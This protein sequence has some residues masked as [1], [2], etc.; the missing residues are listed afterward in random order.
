MLPLILSN[1]YD[2]YYKYK[3][4]HMDG[5]FYNSTTPMELITMKGMSTP[6]SFW[7]YSSGVSSAATSPYA[8]YGSSVNMGGASTQNLGTNNATV[9]SN[10][11][12][13]S[14]NFLIRIWFK[15]TASKY[16]RILEFGGGDSIALS[17]W[18]FWTN[19][20]GTQWAFQAGTGGSSIFTVN[21]TSG[22]S[23]TPTYVGS[24]T[25]N[26]WTV[27]E[28]T[29]VGNVWTCYQGTNRTQVYQQTLS[30]AINTTS[31]GLAVGTDY[32]TT[33]G[34]PATTYNNETQGQFGSIEIWNGVGADVI[35]P[36]TTI[37][38]LN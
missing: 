12:F 32:R 5:S 26:T 6:S 30:G 2:P 22:A 15:P 37:K 14:N 10:L 1:N 34:S 13:G 33:W 38:K 35:G 20:T 31:Y 7:T 23:N 11:A 25:L 36:P 17:P 3:V 4:F 8:N 27:I 28:A 24:L 16:H 18:L 21:N 9:H 19:S 29:R